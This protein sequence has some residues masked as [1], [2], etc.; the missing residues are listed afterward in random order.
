MAKRLEVAVGWQEVDTAEGGR[1][2]CATLE[3]ILKKR[4]QSDSG[5]L[6]CVSV[7]CSVSSVI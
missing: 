3:D 4:L 6:V 2:A 5:K 7:V 1:E